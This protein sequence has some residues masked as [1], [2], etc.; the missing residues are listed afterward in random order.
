MNWSWNSELFSKH[1]AVEEIT[2]KKIDLHKT[3]EFLYV[4]TS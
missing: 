2:K 3:I 4:K 1:R